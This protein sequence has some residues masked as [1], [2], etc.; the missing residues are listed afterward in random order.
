MPKT[1]NLL[2]LSVLP[3]TARREVKDFY[4]FLVARRKIAKN[5]STKMVY[6]P[7]FADLCG[8]LTWKGDAVATQRRLRD[9][10]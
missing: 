9:E 10:W 5:T 8:T 4:Q 7:R 2:D 3:A 6:G 1:A